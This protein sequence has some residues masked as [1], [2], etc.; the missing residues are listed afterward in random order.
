MHVVAFNLFGQFPLYLYSLFLAI[1]ATAGLLWVAWHSPGE[2]LRSHLDAG[3][4]ALLGGLVGGRLLY[5]GMHWTYF[6]GVPIEIPQVFLGGLSWPGI[7]L[8]GL[9]ALAVYANLK[10]KSLGE[11]ADAL[12][13]LAV[14]LII[15]AWLAS[16]FDGSAYGPAV[17]AWWALPSRD[18]WGLLLPRLPLQILG[19]LLTLAIFWLVDTNRKRY[20]FPG[21]AAVL[22]GA[23]FSLLFFALSFFRVD[24]APLYHGLPID[25]WAALGIFVF[26]CGI[27]LVEYVSKWF[28]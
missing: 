9:L 16:W 10:G 12:L 22:A 26:A 5:V 19:A 2:E 11:L 7:L 18:E 28:S 14:A 6:Q 27:M 25:A 24:P 23:L 8:G 1:G 15:A 13:P 21:Q 3:L 17:D 4:L 20:F